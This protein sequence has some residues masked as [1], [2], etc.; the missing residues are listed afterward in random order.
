[1]APKHHHRV[2][3]LQLEAEH[4]RRQAGALQGSLDHA[5]DAI[6]HLEDLLK[7]SWVLERLQQEGERAD[8]DAGRRQEE[9]GRLDAEAE[10]VLGRAVAAEELGGR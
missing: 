7:S 5:R 10:E 6:D 2:E 9:A 1:M 4:A 8:V 3:C